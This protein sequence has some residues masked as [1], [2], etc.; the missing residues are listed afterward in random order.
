MDVQPMIFMMSCWRKFWVR[1]N[2]ERWAKFRQKY[3]PCSLKR[4]AVRVYRNQMP[5]TFVPYKSDTCL[6]IFPPLTAEI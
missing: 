1:K 2:S 6:S 5:N 3:W 4:V